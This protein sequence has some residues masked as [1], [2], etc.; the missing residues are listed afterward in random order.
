MSQFSDTEIS[1]SMAKVLHLRMC[2]VK[3]RS[4][5][6]YSFTDLAKKE[7]QILKTLHGFTD[8]VIVKRRA[9]LLN[10]QAN[11]SDEQNDDVGMKKKMALL[12]V[13]LQ[14]TIDGK[15]LTN[16]DIREEVDTFMFEGHDTTTSGIIFGLYCLAKNP[17][18]QEKVLKEIHEVLGEDKTIPNTMQKLNDMPY[19]DAT[20]K[21]ILRMFSPVP[22]IARYLEEDL[23]LG[24]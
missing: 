6:F 14:S 5:F 19:F 12:D 16:A 10:Q 17:E 2:D 23:Q 4:D 20:I 8:S 7:R 18:V 11:P 22:F 15:P 24:Q 13:L 1:F 9:E 21:E 3:Y